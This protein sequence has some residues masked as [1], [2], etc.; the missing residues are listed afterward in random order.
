MFSGGIRVERGHVNM[1][2]RPYRSNHWTM[3][4]TVSKLSWTEAASP[5]CV[6]Q[7][8]FCRGRRF[9]EGKSDKPTVSESAGS[10]SLSL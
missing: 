8:S 4:E 10:A 6:Q 2:G 9:G 1:A 7:F 5:T 3:S